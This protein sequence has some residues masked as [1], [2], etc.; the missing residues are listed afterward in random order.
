LESTKWEKIEKVKTKSVGFNEK[1][2]DKKRFIT[3]SFYDFSGS[4][5]QFGNKYNIDVEINKRK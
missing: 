2:N 3:I 1:I 4:G 5:Q